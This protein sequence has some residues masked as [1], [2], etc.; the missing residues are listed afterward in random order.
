MMGDFKTSRTDQP[1]NEN[2]DIFEAALN[3]STNTKNPIKLT[4]KNLEYEVNIT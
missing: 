3:A 4:F 1:L 2:E